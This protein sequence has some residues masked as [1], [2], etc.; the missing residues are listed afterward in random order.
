[1]AA[2]RP[3]RVLPALTALHTTAS[4]ASGFH[5]ATSL[6]LTPACLTNRA[7]GH[8]LRVIRNLVCARSNTITV[9]DVALDESA[10]VRGR[11]EG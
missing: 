8:G 7:D 2:P 1:M 4:P 11:G 3:T 10:E 9:Y 6:R 5:F